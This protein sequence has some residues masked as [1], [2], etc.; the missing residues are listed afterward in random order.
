MTDCNRSIHAKKI[1]YHCSKVTS[2]HSFVTASNISF[3]LCR[4]LSVIRC[5]SIPKSQKSH[6]LW[7]GES[8]ECAVRIMML[9]PK[10]LSLS[11]QYGT[12]NCPCTRQI[13]PGFSGRQIRSFQSA[14]PES[15]SEKIIMVTITRVLDT[16]KNALKKW[17]SGDFQRSYYQWDFLGMYPFGA[18]FHQIIVL[19]SHRLI[20]SLFDLIPLGNIH[21]STK[22]F[23]EA[24]FAQPQESDRSPPCYL[25]SLKLTY[26]PHK[27]PNMTKRFIYCG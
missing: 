16:D 12:L 14:T 1:F 13:R 3:G 6:R 5:F 10:R 11:C 24:L 9:C 8:A 25:K 22:G 18:R 2:S 17:I 20:L 15:V 4:C 19:L 7:S 26:S 23:S 21:M 27:Y